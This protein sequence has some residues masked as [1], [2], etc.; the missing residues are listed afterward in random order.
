MHVSIMLFVGTRL[1][2][3]EVSGR[4]VLE[5]GAGNVNGSVRPV[6]ENW[7]R[8][9]EYVGVDIEP[10]PGVDTVCAA[11]NLFEHFGAASVDVVLCLEALE[12]I[13]DWKG[14]ISNMKRVL[15]PGGV[16]LLT[17][18]SEG[19]K[20]HGYPYDYWRFSPAD[21]EMVFS[22]FELLA[23]EPDPQDPGVLVKARRPESFTEG[24]LSGFAALSIVTGDRRATLHDADFDHPHYHRI[25]ARCK[26]R[27]FRKKLRGVRRQIGRAHV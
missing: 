16:L 1:A 3:E 26:R 17:A 7:G 20:Y 19:F 4:S 8:P 6:I 24:D 23:A 14:A 13:R 22:D 2:P 12:H 21:M 10:G 9:A 25:L 18:R 27:A 5:V 11:E 15:S